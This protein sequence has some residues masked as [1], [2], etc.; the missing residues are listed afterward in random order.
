MTKIIPL[1]MSCFYETVVMHL[2]ENRLKSCCAVP[3]WCFQDTYVIRIFAN[4]GWIEDTLKMSSVIV[5]MRYTGG[6]TVPFFISYFFT[7]T[8]YSRETIFFFFL[9]FKTFCVLFISFFTSIFLKQHQIWFELA[10][11]FSYVHVS[12]DISSK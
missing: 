8:L 3:G 10:D 9:N 1:I 7:D 4:C 5:M 11:L 6:L 2:S 12:R